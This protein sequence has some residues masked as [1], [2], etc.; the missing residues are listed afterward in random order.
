MKNQFRKCLLAGLLILVFSIPGKLFAQLTGV[1]TIPG[2]YA[3]ITAAVNALNA[4]GVGAGGVTFNIDPGFTETI[5]AIISLT[6]TG[7]AAN[8]IAFQKDPAASGANPLITAYTGGTG[9]PATAIQDGIWRLIG[10]D[11]V[12]IDGIDIRGNPSNTTNPSTMEYGYALYKQSLSNGCQN[13]TIQNCTITLN[14]INND[15]GAGPMVDGSTGILVVNSTA[16]AATTVLLP[17][18]AAGTNSN[19]SFYSNTIQNCNTGIALIGFAAAS[20]FVAADQNNDIGGTSPSTGNTIINFGGAAAAANPAVAIRTLAQYELNV[21]YNTINNNTGA[22]VN[23]ENILRGIY[24]NTAVSAKSAITNNTITLK[25][26]GTTQTLTAIENVS[27]TTAVGNEVNISNNTITNCSYTTATT[28]S[29]YGIYN[30]GAPAILNINGNSFLNNSTAATAT[31]P[32]YPIYNNGAATLTININDNNIN[33]V[34]FTAA[35]SVAFVGIYNLL[36]GS[37]AALSITNN[38]IQAV[39]YLALSTAANTYIINSAATLSQFI[40]SN[41]F[42]NLNVNTTG[43]IIFIS[44]SVVVPGT[45]NQ[46]VDDNGIVG[47]FKRSSTATSGTLILFSSS[48]SST[49]GSIISNSNNEFS[50]ITVYGAATISGWVNTDAGASAKTLQGNVFSNWTGG[51]GAVTV[52]SVNITGAVNATVSNLISN[53][54]SA[55]NIT[56][57]STAAGN[58]NIY[59]NSVTNL[60]STGGTSTIVTGIAVGAGTTKNIYFN[61]ISGLSGSAITTGSINGITVAGSATVNIYN[62]KISA[63]SGSATTSGTINAVWVSAGTT[64]SVYRNKIYNISSSSSAIVTGGLVNGIYVTGST[65]NAAIALRNNIIGDIKA[66]AANLADPVRG[67]SL[68]STGTTSNL[69]VYYNTIHLSASSTGTNFGATGVYHA[70]SATTT[71]ATLDMRNNI[72]HNN[73]VFSG[74]GLIVAY[75]RSGISLNNYSSSSNNNLFYGGT[76]SANN[77][78]FYDGTNADQTLA[79]FKIR[80]STRDAASVSEDL[81]T[82]SKF[83]STTGSSVNYLH[84]DDSKSSVV[85]SGAA[86]I[87][88]VNIDFD[89]DIRQ[90]N[91]G[92]AGNGTAP[93][94]GADEYAGITYTPLTGTYNVGTGQTF[95]SLTNAGGLFAKINRVG[96]SGNVTVNITSDLAELGTEDLIEWVETGAGNYSLTIQPNNTTSRLISGDVLAGMIRLNGADKVII[97][98]GAT[99]ALTFRNTNVSGTTGAAFIFINGATNNIIRNCNVEAYTNAT[100]AVILFSTAANIDGGNSNNLVQACNINATVAG[101]NGIVAILTAGTN[102]SGFENTNNSIINNNVYNYRDRGLEIKSIGSTYWTISGNSFYNGGIS[103]AINYAAGTALHGIRILGGAGHVVSANYIGG[104]AALSAGSPAVYA[105]SAGNI[106]YQGILYNS[107]NSLPEQS[108][109]SNTIANI[110]LSSVPVAASST[111][112]TGIE[113]NGNFINIGGVGLGNTIGSNTVNGSISISTS[114]TKTTN[115]SIARGIYCNSQGGLVTGNQVSGFDINNAGGTPAPTAFAGIYVNN[116]AAPGMVNNNII[117]STGA[118]AV[119]SSIRV[120]SG[121]TCTTTSLTGISIGTSVGSAVNVDGNLV[122]NFGFANTAVTISVGGIVGILSAAKP[123]AEVNITNNIFES[124]SLSATATTALFYGVQNTGASGTVR[125]NGNTFRG[126]IIQTTTTVFNAIRNTGAV[127]NA[128]EINSNILGETSNPLISYTVANSGAQVFIYN[129]GG[130]P[131]ADL[132]ISNNSFQNINYAVNGTG[133]NTFI[134]NVVATLSQTI[135]SNNFINLNPQTSGSSTFITNSVIV[136]AAGTQSVSNNGITGTFSKRVG[137]TVTFLT[138]AATCATGSTININNNNFSN[139]TVTG[140]TV[141]NGIVN[142]DGGNSNKTIQGNYLTNWSGG[143]LTLTGMN[144]NLTGV[145]NA[146]TGNVIRNISCAS[147]VVGLTT[148]AGNDNIYLNTIDSLYSTGGTSTNVTGIAVTAGTS[149]NIYKNSVSNLWGTAMTTGSVRGILL[150]GVGTAVSLTQNTVSTL[151]A[152][153]LTTGSVTGIWVSAGTTISISRNKIYDISCTGTTLTA[154]IYGIQVSGA[155]V[156]LACTINNNLIGDLRT[157]S[158]SNA[159]AIRGIGMV[160]TGATSASSVYYNTIFLN[161]TST[162]TNF[163]NSGI[164][165]TASG[166]ATT[167]ALDIRN[168]NIT[169]ISTARGTGKTVAYRRSTTALGNYAAASNNNMFYAGTP[170]VSNLIFYDGTNTDQTIAAFKTRV[171]TRETN[172][173]SEDLVTGNIFLSTTGSSTFFLHIDL[174]KTTALKS[175]GVQISGFVDDFD[176]DIRFG[177]AGS[178]NNGTAPDIGADEFTGYQTQPF[179]GIINVG[180][181]QNYTS[182]TNSNGLFNKINSLGFSGHVTVNIVS[183]LAETGAEALNQWTETGAGSY[184]LKIQPDATT[185]WLISGNVLA[186]LIRFNGADRVNVDGGTGKYLTFR[187]TNSTGTTGTAFT[188]INGAFGDTIRNCSIEAYANSTNGIILISTSASVA[189]GNSNLLIE[190][191]QIKGTVAGNTA[192][193]GIYSAGTA[194]KENANVKVLNNKIYDFRDRGIEVTATGSTGWTVSGNSIYNGSISGN[195]NYD[196]SSVL[197]GLRILGGSGYTIQNNFIGGSDT[198]TIGPNA[199]Y[200]STIGNISYKGIVLTTTSASP[201]SIIKGNTISR[202]TVNS[203][204]QTTAAIAFVGIE[205]GGSGISV[206]GAGAGE[207]N[208]IGSNSLNSA[209]SVVTN[210]SSSTNT[211][212][213]TGINSLHS[214]GVVTANQVAGIDISNIGSSPAGSVFKGIYI[215]NATAPAQVNSNIVGS[216]GS[217]A[218]TNSIQVLSASTA[219]NNSLAGI[220]IGTSVASAVQLNANVVRNLSNLSTTSSGTFTG[221]NNIATVSGAVMTITNCHISNINA[222][223]NADVTSGLYAGIVSSSPSTIQSDTIS[224]I[225]LAA[226]GTAAQIKGIHV[227]GAFVQSIYNNWISDFSTASTKIADAETGTPSG[228]TIIGILSA[229]SVSGQLIYDNTLSNFA[230]TTTEALNTAIVGIGAITT[231]NAGNIY[232]NR[233]SAFTNTS[234]G[235][236]TLS[237]ITGIMGFNGSYN[238]YDNVIKFDNSSNA[239]GIKIYGITHATSNAWNYYYNSVKIAGNATGVAARTADFV[240]TV[241]GTVALL[242]NV[243]INQRTGTGSHFSISNKV[244]TPAT[245]W[246]GAASNYNDLYSANAAYTGEWGNAVNSTFAQWKTSSGGDNNSVNKSATFVA[247]TYDLVP[248]STTN[249]ALNNSATPISSPIVISA[250][251]N[252]AGRHATTP[253]MGAYE[254]TFSVFSVTAG[255]NS[256]VCASG[257]ISLT[258]SAPTAYSPT[259]SWTDPTTTIVAT[260]QNPT[261]PAMAGLFTVTVTDINGC[262]A[263]ASTTV[264]IVASPS[265]YFSYPGTPYCSGSGTATISFTGTTGGVFSSTAG[266]TVN[267]TTGAVNLGASTPA[268]YTVTYTIP[269]G[270]G[271]TQFD[272]TASIA[273][274]LGGSWTGNSSTDWNTAA[275]WLCGSVPPANINIIIPGSRPNYPVINAGIVNINSLTINSGA[276]LSITTATL[277][278]AGSITNSGTCT[279]TN[280]TIEFNGSTAQTIPSGMFVT[281]TIKHLTV[282]N[283]AGVTLGGS[284]SLTGQLTV[285][286][287]S[288]ATGDSLTLKSSAT[289]TAMVGTITSV[290]SVPINGKVTVERYIQGRRKYRLLTSSVTT[291]NATSLT[292]GQEALSIW[293]NWQSQGSNAAANTGMFITGGTA[294]DGFDTQLGS[295]SMFTYHDSLRKYIGFTTANG[296]NTK[297]TPLK[298][299]IAYYTFVYGDR[300]NSLV[301]SNPNATVIKATGTLLTGDQVYTNASAIPLTNVTGRYTLLGNPYASTINWGTVTKTNIADTYWG[302]DPNLNGTGGYVTVT[303][304]GGVTLIAPFSGTTGLNQYIQPGQGFFV[305]TTAANPQLQIKE[306]DKTS[307]F[308]STAFRQDIVSQ[309]PLMAIN[310]LTQSGATKILWDGTLAAFDDSYSNQVNGEDAPKMTTTAEN[311]GIQNGTDMLSIETRKIPTIADTMQLNLQRLTKAQYILQIF[312]MNMV[313]LNMRPYLE[314]KYLQTSQEISLLD[315]NFITFNVNTTIPASFDSSRFRIVYRQLAI[316]P[317]TFTSVDAKKGINSNEVKWTVAQEIGIDR[318]FVERSADGTNFTKTGDVVSKGNSASQSYTW[319]DI[320]PLARINYYRIRAVEQSGSSIL[321]KTVFVKTEDAKSGITVFPNPV[322]DQK[323]NVSF[324]E[325]PKGAYNLQLINTQGQVVYQLP[326]EHPGGTKTI[327]ILVP[328]NLPKAVYY[329]LIKGDAIKISQKLLL[330]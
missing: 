281:N 203:V 111:T 255:S 306:S 201:A 284:L 171:S 271:C 253:D 252:L 309:V 132:S 305:R 283:T 37:G 28:G 39:N 298:A 84:M 66:T 223:A 199:V 205:T 18:T 68:L 160:S 133:A 126:N 191:N 24:I 179:S 99:K 23:H 148:A 307:D 7:T 249:C 227:S 72:I 288:L 270:N 196:A 94:I 92:Y 204:P 218:A 6:A 96:L 50:N 156:N 324:K 312:T 43:T 273:L 296:K 25:S 110:S 41:N 70:V 232:R 185:A 51:T 19:N 259:Y 143:T 237:G 230:S 256:P 8:P 91:A 127:F 3:T 137:G 152:N 315:T 79:A 286:N 121:S 10:S 287:G 190:N 222:A 114:S 172:S 318:Y 211:S 176:G 17:T 251:I 187:N 35:T 279:A 260:T 103:G 206:G 325:T 117:G 40:S 80:M 71:T 168:N 294:G 250:D 97:D 261:V 34:N 47:S 173:I 73:S 197:H 258:S 202:I 184:T 146:I 186:G 109:T 2:D 278:I 246:S 38:N 128:I 29:F 164:Y 239:N 180:T 269:A 4:A 194:G 220:E 277:K 200:A 157:P 5:T 328:G 145:N 122:K 293:G 52:M 90:G 213:I 120:I 20:P 74:T 75:R 65:A 268:A 77:L 158:L 183:D 142:T 98:G 150:S 14:R 241:N 233:I 55:G 100:N 106:T 169:N 289:G 219:T 240:R 11:Y 212:I 225:L 207:G 54:T 247:S 119:S 303:S 105:S 297:Y 159:D 88:G 215:N 124:N 323:L 125:I 93:D 189:G 49:S 149:K 58:D 59:N 141:I 101:N 304:I 44:N 300:Q 107:L 116:T 162:G 76:P 276:T 129:G 57:I 195:F 78:I 138:S 264:A 139:V 263:S 45:G 231:G 275:N 295:A 42:T 134:S 153:T 229:G 144:I 155:T 208:L 317:V 67:I 83:L 313:P 175:G 95:T 299:G 311:I 63:I 267:S 245:N 290:A 330:Q 16:T 89:N 292:V 282:N 136:P 308:N 280:G 154:A 188:F 244:A 56:G 86:N 166:T 242:N 115:T 82:G 12:T 48:A 151:Y 329:L 266:L 198:L 226:T 170:G 131:T 314:D 262:S 64:V 320:Q 310:L 135:E 165:H 181:G 274:I 140:A 69:Y 147:I 182:L 254:F 26:A 108:I 238:V 174:N 161:A 13:V 32:Y 21:S 53:I 322:T 217:G 46:V 104:S 316:L 113:T 272:T 87:A 36:G 130:A 112:F 257:S 33:G 27:G 214:G 291:S 210:A 243:F 22:G 302:W 221:I 167:A 177:N 327:V 102:V 235:T 265:A 123:S 62:N 326:V 15:A 224:N 9:T 248:D 209:I 81:I 192:L 319:T 1:K 321:S 118:G 85:K 178:S 285:T 234:E 30:T 228:Y 193:T 301:T 61:T 236:S 60:S 31:G 163:G 216:T